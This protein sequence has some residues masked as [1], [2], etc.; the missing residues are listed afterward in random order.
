MISEDIADSEVLDELDEIESSTIGN[1]K[2]ELNDLVE[3]LSRYGWLA[4]D[5]AWPAPMVRKIVSAVREYKQFFGIENAQLYEHLMQPRFCGHPDRM[6]V[7]EAI[8]RWNPGN[9]VTVSVDGSA[10]LSGISRTQL[11]D[12]AG[13]AFAG[14]SE[15]CGIRFQV[16]SAGVG[17]IHITT[18][19]IDGPSGTLAWS[20]LPGTNTGSNGRLTQKYDSAEPWVIAVNPPGNKTDLVR[21]I[22]HEG[23]HAIGISHIGNGNLM[24]PM[25]S[26]TIHKPQAGDI[27]EAQARY[28]KPSG[29]PAPA[30]T[31][32]PQPE[33]TPEPTPPSTP[34]GVPVEYI[35]GPYYRRP[36]GQFVKY[37][38][39]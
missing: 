8:R 22:R 3:L 1:G 14:W 24:A 39:R 32:Q 28:G 21:V 18:G 37:V 38:M 7:S 23:G 13:E 2:L 9:V 35:D 6:E 26:R 11:L 19:R 16:L 10:Q 4:K 25:Y 15:V 5:G 20:E 17:N 33:P 36:D 29:N 31:P 27:A 30:P 12:A 34:D